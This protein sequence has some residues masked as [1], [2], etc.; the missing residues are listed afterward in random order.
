MI[1]ASPVCKFELEP[2]AKYEF[3]PELY[4]SPLGGGVTSEFSLRTFIFPLYV[5]AF[6]SSASRISRDPL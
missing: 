5:M 3:E 6:T 1:Q 2:E 4:A